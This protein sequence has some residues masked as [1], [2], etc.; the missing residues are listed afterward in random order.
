MFKHV[1]DKNGSAKTEDISKKWCV[2]IDFAF[3][4]SGHV[5]SKQKSDEY[6]WY[7]DVAEA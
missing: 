6:A 3:S 5:K 4:F 1:H 2:K 7:D